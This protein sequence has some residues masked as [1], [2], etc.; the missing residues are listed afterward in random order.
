MANGDKI[1][2]GNVYDPPERAPEWVRARLGFNDEDI[3]LL[4]QHVKN[5]RVYVNVLESKAG[6]LYMTIDTYEAKAGGKAAPTPKPAP[7]PAAQ[8]P[9]PGAET[10]ELSPVVTITPEDDDIRF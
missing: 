9:A 5:G 6:G 8:E 2:V 7:T 1:F 3:S 10:Q 4:R